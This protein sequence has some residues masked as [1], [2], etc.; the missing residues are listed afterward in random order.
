M[1]VKEKLS[2]TSRDVIEMRD[3]D[4]LQ[5]KFCALARPKKLNQE[6][7]RKVGIVVANSEFPWRIFPSP[8]A[9]SL[10]SHCSLGR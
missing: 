10:G 6:L 9:A 7:S 1:Y 8:V 3:I 4:Q 2:R 5:T